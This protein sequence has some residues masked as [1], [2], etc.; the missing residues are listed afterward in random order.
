MDRTNGVM[1][2]AELDHGE[3]SRGTRELLTVART[4][5]NGLG[6]PVMAALLGSDLDAHGDKLVALGADRAYV[7]DSPAL[8]EY[9]GEYYTEALGEVCRHVGPDIL[10]F[11]HNL[12]GRDLAPRLAFRLGTGLVMDCV[13]LAV[14]T[15]SGQL[16]MTKPVYG[17]KA[18]AVMAAEG[19]RPQLASVRAKTFEP[20][21]PEAGRRG[22]VGPLAVDLKPAQVRV[23][24]RVQQEGTGV[25]VEDAEVVVSGGRGM[26]NADNF[27]ELE[28]LACLL[29][30]AVG[31]SRAAI[32]AGWLP[33][34]QQVGLTGKIVKPRLY[35]A[36]GI[37]GASQHLAGCSGAKAIVAI[38]KDPEAP[39][40]RW[41]HYGVVAE[42]QKVLPSLIDKLHELTAK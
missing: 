38:N 19:A 15:E 22:S 8:K 41:A 4:L 31:G 16:L 32:D 11:S 1:I 39:I 40:F 29:G 23:V 42:W 27:H 26:G 34:T 14:D 9:Q 30:G 13:D 2:F 35:I 25:K 5:A 7:V 21:Q 3:V 10:L 6:Q 37:S 12:V 20:V 33:S 36:V 28:Q 18:L 24:K 17:G